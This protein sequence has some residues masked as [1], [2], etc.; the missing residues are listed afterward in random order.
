M[1]NV[2]STALDRSTL[3]A[4]VDFA[5]GRRQM[6]AKGKK[7]ARRVTDEV[8]PSEKHAETL[9]KMRDHRLQPSG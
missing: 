1:K 9:G 8:A 3:E 2:R 5:G 4:R 6:Q 7:R